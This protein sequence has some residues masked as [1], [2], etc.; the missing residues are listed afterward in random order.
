[1]KVSI[2]AT[3]SSPASIRT[4]IRPCSSSSRK[5]RPSISARGELADQVVAGRGTALADLG[6]GVIREIGEALDAHFRHSGRMMRSVMARMTG[7]SSG[8]RSSID[9]KTAIGICW[10]KSATNSQWPRVPAPRSGAPTIALRR[11]RASS[12]APGSSRATAAAI[13]GV[14]GRVDHQRDDRRLGIGRLGTRMARLEKVS[15]C[16]RMWRTSAP[17][18]ATQCPPLRW[19]QNR[20][21][22]PNRAGGPWQRRNR[23]RGHRRGRCRNRRCAQA[24]HDRGCQ[25]GWGIA[26]R[27]RWLAMRLPSP[28]VVCCLDSWSERQLARARTAGRACSGARARLR[29]CV[30]HSRAVEIVHFGAGEA[31]AEVGA[32]VVQRLAPLPSHWRASV[33]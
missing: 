14:I 9:M 3:V 33:P 5:G 29:R 8:G 21:G 16:S 22:T 27:V 24:A 23:R 13:V 11:Q 10:A 32:E 7:R 31:V 28:L 6:H 26:W 15:P 19:V 17:L 30:A 18:V 12:L 1:M 20:S 4:D 25:S 2:E